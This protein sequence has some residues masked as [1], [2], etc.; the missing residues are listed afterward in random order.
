MHSKNAVRSGQINIQNRIALLI[1]ETISESATDAQKPPSPQ[2]A[3]QQHQQQQPSQQ[4]PSG[5]TVVGGTGG[6]DGTTAATPTSAG[7]VQQS[8]QSQQALPSATP[9]PTTAN[10]H[11]TTGAPNSNQPSPHPSPLYPVIPQQTGQPNGS[12]QGDP[13]LE[14]I[15]DFCES[16]EPPNRA[17]SFGTT[18]NQKEQCPENTAS[19]PIP[20]ARNGI[21]RFQQL[22]VNNTLL[23]PPDTEH[24]LRTTNV[25]L[26]C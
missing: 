10:P 25:R 13:I 9:T 19:A 24:D 21:A 26:W 17:A 12:T 11:S 4:Q 22:I 1:A 18:S 7:N 15:F 6:G 23:V 14:P 3:S 20:I 5:G 8:Q 2:Q 16:S